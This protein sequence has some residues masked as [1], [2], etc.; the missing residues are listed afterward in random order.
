[1]ETKCAQMF[2]LTQSL[3]LG[4]LSALFVQ[5]LWHCLVCS[6]R[7]HLSLLTCLKGERFTIA[8]LNTDEGTTQWV[9]AN[10]RYFAFQKIR[11]SVL[12]AMP[13]VHVF[14]HKALRREKQTKISNMVISRLKLQKHLMESLK[15][16]CQ[17]QIQ[18]LHEWHNTK[19]HK[20]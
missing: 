5:F 7:V 11:K 1:M 17:Q 2:S 13:S 18:L 6:N 19:L 4:F 16:N 20:I 3:L 10:L 8:E 14:A 9:W 15:I 12:W